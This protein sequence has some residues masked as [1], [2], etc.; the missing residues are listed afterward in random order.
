MWEVI[1]GYDQCVQAS[2]AFAN[3]LIYTGGA[4]DH[5]I[6]ALNATTGANEWNFTTSNEI[7]TAPAIAGNTVYVSCSLA[8]KTYALNSETGVFIWS[9]QTNGYI[10]SSPAIVNGVAYFGSYDGNLY[11]IGQ[12]TNSTASVGSG[13]L[14]TYAYIVIIAVLLIVIAVALYM[15]R[16]RRH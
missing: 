5:N 6:Y 2:P 3:G 1:T 10:Y 4:F 8:N 13:A 12:T 14:P 9:F 15:L 11:A 16:K 7:T